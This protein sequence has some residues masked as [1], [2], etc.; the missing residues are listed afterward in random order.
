MLKNALARLM[1]TRQRRHALSV[2]E[3]ESKHVDP[4]QPFPNDSSCFYGGDEAGN[5]AIFRLAFRGPSRA[6]ECWL[7]FRLAGGPIVGLPEN[8][9]P[10][11]DGFAYGDVAFV[12]EEPGKRW[13]IRYQ[14]P[15]AERGGG[16]ARDGALDLVFTATHPLFD[17][18][19]S[20]DR[21]LVAQA[22]ARE[23]WTRAF[24][25]KLK[26]LGQVHYEQFGRLQGT[27][28]FGDRVAELDLL[29]TRDHS[30]G[31]RDWA[32]WE[33]HFWLSGVTADGYGFTAV[34][35]RYDFCGPI[36]AGFTIDPDG[37]SDAIVECTSL[38]E[39]SRRT[40][41]PT[42]G[43]VQLR[44]RSGA[45][46]TL[47]FQRD[48]VF[49]YEGDGLYLMKEG[50]GRFRWDGRPAYGLCEFGFGKA[51]YGREIEGAEGLRQAS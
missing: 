20:T 17:Y 9:G 41:W 18:A 36:Y 50:I 32:N 15:L 6:A 23:R 33:R 47:E 10:E 21:R 31:S 28:R 35:I 26:D 49:A 51:R 24:F 30:F 13:R 29:T 7:D 3:L 4:A 11:S 12:C 44:C 45:R 40:L 39:V 27:V 8:H 5:A 14:G 1:L 37:S 42:E 22:I 16:A 43:V 46:H 48:G 38:E 2:S 19:E 34:A 25:L